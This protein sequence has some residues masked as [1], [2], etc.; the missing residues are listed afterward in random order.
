M[1]VGGSLS[2]GLAV[3]R[4]MRKTRS[5]ALATTEF[6]NRVRGLD[7]YTEAQVGRLWFYAIPSGSGFDI[8]VSHDRR[9]KKYLTSVPS[10]QEGVVCAVDFAVKNGVVDPDSAPNGVE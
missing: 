7:F 8:F 9:N 1:Q 2:L 6:R 4:T 3:D 5:Q 10:L